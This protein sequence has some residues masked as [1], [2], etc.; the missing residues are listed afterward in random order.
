[1]IFKYDKSEKIGDYIY[2]YKG[3]EIIAAYNPFDGF[4]CKVTFYLKAD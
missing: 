3:D 4:F 2:F 1:M